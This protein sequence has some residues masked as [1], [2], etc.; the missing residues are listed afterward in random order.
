MRGTGPGA[1]FYQVDSGTDKHDGK[2]LDK[3]LS[4]SHP[5]C[6]GSL[7]VA[8][9]T[10]T[11]SSFPQNGSLF[12]ADFILLDGIPANVIR[13]EKQYVAAP[14]VMLKM[15]PSGKLL[16]MAIQVRCPGHR[17]PNTALCSTQTSAPSSPGPWLLAPNHPHAVRRVH[18]A[19]RLVC[20]D[21]PN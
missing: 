8:F 2:E 11:D 5:L 15:E 9:Q 12:E 13:G 19:C 10:W 21:S 4:M 18:F 7:G 6:P 14:L 17:P 3:C 1:W 16:P 20:L